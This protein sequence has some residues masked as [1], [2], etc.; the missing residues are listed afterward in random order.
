MKPRSQ[1]EINEELALIDR[2]KSTGDMVIAGMLYK[3]YMHLVYG[4][5]LKYLKHKEDS[6]DAVMQLFE[7]VAESLKT[8]EVSNFKSWLY[9][10][11]KNFCLMQLR[12]KQNKIHTQ[13]KDI[14]RVDMENGMMLHHEDETSVLEDDLSKLELCIEQLQNEQ[15]TCVELFY[16]QKKSYKE[17]VENTSFELK[18][19]KSHVQNGKRNLKICM[20]KSK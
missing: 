13:T 1:E 12:S 17:I 14:D 8:H 19:V 6:Q 11:S 2:Y 7:K 15:K 10:V 9:V 3:K 18:K 20:E 5:C 4:L 16:L